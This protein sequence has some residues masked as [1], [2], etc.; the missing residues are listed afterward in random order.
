MAKKQETVNVAAAKA[1]LPE[2]VERASAGEEIIL[3]RNGKPKAKLVPIAQKKRYVFGAGKVKWKGT[4]RVLDKPL[5]E[6]ILNAFYQSYDRRITDYRCYGIATA[7]EL[8]RRS[9]AA[10]GQGDRRCMGGSRFVS[11]SSSPQCSG[12]SGA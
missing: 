6:E 10:R 8:E 1:R 2:L 5:P 9:F 7:E 12:T 11:R 4:E 3:A